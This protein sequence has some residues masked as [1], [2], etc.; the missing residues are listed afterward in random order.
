ML[1]PKQ[2][3]NWCHFMAPIPQEVFRSAFWKKCSVELGFDL[4]RLPVSYLIAADPKRVTEPAQGQDKVRILAGSRSYKAF[5]RWTGCS[6]QGILEG[7]FLKRHSRSAYV[8]LSESDL[9]TVLARE[10]IL[11]S[12]DPSDSQ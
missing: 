12:S 9:T 11:P 4:R 2:A 6:A 7:E 1:D 8:A 5:C 3:D 10:E